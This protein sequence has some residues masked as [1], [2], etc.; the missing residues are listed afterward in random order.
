MTR[1]LDGNGSTLALGEE[2]GKGGEGAVFALRDPKLCAKIYHNPLDADRARKIRAMAGIATDTLS[3]L[4]SWPMDLVMD[5]K[6]RAMGLVIPRVPDGKDIHRLYSPRS[7]RTDF[8]RADWRFLIRAGANTARAFAAVHDAGHVIGDVNHGSILVAQDATVRLIDCDSFQVVIGGTRYVCGLGVETYPPPALP[9]RSFKDVLRTVDHDAFG[10][11]VLIFHLLMMGRH[12]F[13]GRYLGAGDMPIPKA[14]EEHRFAYGAHRAQY[15]MERPPGAPD[16]AIVG[17]LGPLFER[18]FAR[19]TQASTRP[20]AQEWAAGLTKLETALRQCRSNDAHWHLAT[21][22]EC[23]WCRIEGATGLTLFPLVVQAASGTSAF[24]LDA[25][26]RQMSAIGHPGPTPVIEV[27]EPA[28]SEKALTLRWYGLKR[29]G[30]AVASAFVAF[31][32]L[33]AT[34]FPLAAFLGAAAGFF[35]IRRLLDK[36]ADLARIRS[37]YEERRA[38]WSKADALWCKAAAPDDFEQKR[39]EVLRAVEVWKGL[40]QVRL[41]RLAQLRTDQRRLQLTRFLDSHLIEKANIAGIGPTRRSA[42]AS[43][44]VETAAD[45]TPASVRV[46]GFGPS[47][48]GKLLAWRSVLE[49]RFVFDPSRPVDPRDIARLEQELVAERRR[50]ED[51]LR[52]GVAALQQAKARVLAV[53]GNMRSQVESARLAY[54]QAEVDRRTAG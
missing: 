10:L 20:S 28:P 45:V 15:Q 34:G 51:D 26:V 47:L 38:E 48:Q 4:T 44:G 14:I 18:A 25:L 41:Q 23:P 13:S 8:V 31:L 29:N 6:G 12:P 43:E 50:I 40:P 36:D 35:A 2:L 1:Y 22:G 19:P 46:P 37:A 27:S 33:L 30:T 52:N 54:L 16:L 53:R 9:G 21:L 24:E 42:L 11:A 5:D 3:R 39:A 7:R 17:D 32:T 49:Q